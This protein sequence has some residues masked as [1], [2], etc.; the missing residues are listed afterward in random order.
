MG[1]KLREKKIPVWDPLS[2]IVLPDTPGDGCEAGAG[3][4][5][6]VG[7]GEGCGVGLSVG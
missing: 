5:C 7:A 6:G 2:F 3:K 1:R 4:G